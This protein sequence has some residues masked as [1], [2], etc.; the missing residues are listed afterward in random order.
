MSGE[1][2]IYQSDDGTIR[3]ETR[4]ENETLW[5]TQQQMAALFQATQQNISQ[6]INN[7][8]AEGELSL[9]ATHKKSLWVRQE[10]NRQVER[11]LDSY[12]LDMVISVGYRIKSLIATRFRIW[13]TH[14]LKEYIIKGFVMDDERLKNPPTVDA[15]VPDYFDEW[16]ARIRDIRASEKRMYLR[17]REIF[18]FAADYEPSLPET[19]QFFSTIQNK[20]HFAATGYTAAELIAQRVNHILPNMGLTNW[21]EDE[22]RKTDV[23]IAKNYLN[24]HEITELNR[25]VTM[26]LDFA[27]DQATRRKQVF[28]QDWQIKLDEFL[29]LNNRDVLPDTGKISKKMADEKAQTEYERFATHRREAKELMGESELIKQFEAA[30]KLAYTRKQKN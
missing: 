10:G 14:Q 15:S 9:Q 28:M 5:L 12:N 4:L 26:W 20:L 3:L 24:S 30:T 19:N 8:Y 22:V 21:A 23:T 7:I 6:H 17:V 11:T 13:A 16:L 27:E 29:R 1:I 2:I 25:I 18:A